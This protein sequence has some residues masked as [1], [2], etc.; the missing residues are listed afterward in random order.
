LGLSCPTVWGD[1][2]FV[3][4]AISQAK[5]KPTLRIG[6]YGDVVP[7]KEEEPHTWKVYCLDTNS[8]R[9]VWDRTSYTGVPKIKRHPKSSHANCTPA[10]DGKVVIACFGSE[11]LYCYTVDG[12]LL[13]KKELGKLASGWFFNPEYE[14]GFG[15]SPILYRDLVIVQCD[16]GKDSFIAAYRVADGSIAWQTPRRSSLLGHADSY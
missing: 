16:I 7:L 8:G 10:T 6:Q 4:T 15:S 12:E 5:T 11:G 13:W 14:W 2:L 1:R 3:T 9:M